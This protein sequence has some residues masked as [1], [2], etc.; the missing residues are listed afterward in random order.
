MQIRDLVDALHTR[1][2]APSRLTQDYLDEQLDILENFLDDAHDLIY[3]EEDALQEATE[4]WMQAMTGDELLAARRLYAS[5]SA[6][7]FKMARKQAQKV[8]TEADLTDEILG[9]TWA[10][11][12]RSLV[13]YD[14]TSDAHLLT[15]LQIDMRQ[16]LQK[17]L[18]QHLDRKMTQERMYRKVLQT[19]NAVMAR[20]GR[21]ATQE[22]L[23]D[24]LM[25]T[26]WGRSVSREAITSLLHL[27]QRKGALSL[28]APTQDDDDTSGHDVVPDRSETRLDTSRLKHRL[29]KAWGKE[30][31]VRTLDDE[32]EPEE[33]RKRTVTVCGTEIRV[34]GTAYVSTTDVAK[35][36]LGYSTTTYLTKDIQ[37][38]RRR[39]G[40]NSYVLIAAVRD[41]ARQR[42]RHPERV[43]ALQAAL[44]T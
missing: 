37:D 19:E 7:V 36:L 41:V 6:Y 3:K 29:A 35:K 38:A 39:H 4:T 17:E 33:L 5:S 2:S 18:A 26:S 15:W 9:W 20:E 40:R 42:D 11:F 22:E 16:Q 30:Q 8:E 23:V 21:E 12:L 27:L 13:R 24:V 10:V 43:E 14:R 1:Y 32:A 44:Q 28:D 31:T 34:A 25:D